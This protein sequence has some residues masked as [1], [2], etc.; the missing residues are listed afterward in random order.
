MG[1]DDQLMND[2]IKYASSQS[3]KI[4]VADL[5]KKFKLGLMRATRIFA[6]IES[7]YKKGGIVIKKSRKKEL[8]LVLCEAP[9]GS[10][11]IPP[12]KLKKV[13]RIIFKAGMKCQKLHPDDDTYDDIHFNDAL[14][15]VYKSFPKD[16]RPF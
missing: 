9:S 8:K 6:F 3:R 12:K 7:E 2:C 10:L 15:K 5:Q 16:K 1:H 11:I 4:T 13:F 14:A